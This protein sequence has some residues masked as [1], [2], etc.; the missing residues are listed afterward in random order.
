M[1]MPRALGGRRCR[2]QHPRT[3]SP[4]LPVVCARRRRLHGCDGAPLCTST[5]G[6]AVAKVGTPDEDAHRAR[7]PP[8]DEPGC[9]A[10]LWLAR[11]LLAL[12]CEGTEAGAACGD[13]PK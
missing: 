4:A 11:R 12:E 13:F 5:G 9:R 7:A 2:V 8:G 1:R 3:S 6:L 10:W